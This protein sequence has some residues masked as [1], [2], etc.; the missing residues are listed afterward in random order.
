MGNLVVKPFKILVIESDL[1]LCKMLS[2]CFNESGFDYRIYS[3]TNNIVPLVLDFQPD[4][5]LLAYLSPLLNGG[6]LLFRSRRIN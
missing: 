6:E 3:G 2:L 5:V 1:R 4:L